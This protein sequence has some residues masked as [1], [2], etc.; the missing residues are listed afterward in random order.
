MKGQRRARAQEIA[1][2]RMLLD[3]P[4]ADV[5]I[6]NPT[7]YAVA[8]K[9]S[10]SKGSAPVCVAKGVDEVA[11]RIRAVAETA[12][13]PVHSDAPTARALHATVEIGREIAPE[14]Y[15]AVAAAIRF[16]DRMRRAARSR[17]RRDRAPPAGAADPGGGPQGAGP[18]GAGGAGRRGPAARR[19]AGGA[20]RPPCAGHG[21]GSA[22]SRARPAAPLGRGA[23]AAIRAARAAL[24][25]ASR[26][27]GRRRRRRWASGRRSTI[28]RAEQRRRRGPGG[29]RRPSRNAR[30]VSPVDRG[31]RRPAPAVSADRK[32]PASSGPGRGAR[33]RS[34]TRGLPDRPRAGASAG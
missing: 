24:A 33:R 26:R 1:T 21:G 18:G 32:G 7:H 30:R 5:V 15:R 10:R 27:R 29:R 23:G 17:G 25:P 9:W 8:L 11:L 13:I 31:R 34:E 2:N 12:R 4:K 28:W 22:P 3:V 6:V 19:G 16:A 14:Q 20:G